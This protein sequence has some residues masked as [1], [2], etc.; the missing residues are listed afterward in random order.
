MCNRVLPTVVLAVL[1]LCSPAIAADHTVGTVNSYDSQAKHLVLNGG[2]TY[3]FPQ[4]FRDPG[5]KA[6][7]HVR[8]DWEGLR[9]GMRLASAVTKIP[10]TR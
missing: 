1:V 10:L 7:D 6:G 8:I 2:V 3:S 4:D 9:D 5:L